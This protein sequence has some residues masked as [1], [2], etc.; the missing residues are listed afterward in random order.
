MR[1]QYCGIRW[2]SREGEAKA[3]RNAASAFLGRL[4]P[5]LHVRCVDFCLSQ[6]PLMEVM[7]LRADKSE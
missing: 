5:V 3:W 6:Q 4:I 7:L 1:M 2:G